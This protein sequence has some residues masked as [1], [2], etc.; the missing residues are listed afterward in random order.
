[1]L[2]AELPHTVRF[3]ERVQPLIDHPPDVTRA[4]P[5]S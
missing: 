5:L 1:M 2:V 4:R 3:L